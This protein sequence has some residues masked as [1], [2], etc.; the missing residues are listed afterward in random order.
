MVRVL[1]FVLA[2]ALTGA[3]AQA[4]EPLRV[5]TTVAQIADVVREVAGERAQVTSLMGE[6]VDPHTYRQTRADIVALKRA[7]LVLYNGLYLEAQ[8]EDLLHLL[9]RHQPVIA[10]GEFIPEDL[11]L[12]HLQYP[13]KYDPHIWMDVALW[14]RT[15]PPIVEVLTSLD[16]EGRET[17]ESRGAAYAE[18][19]EE[20]DEYV[21]AKMD[22]VPRE[23]RVLLTAHDAFRYFARAYDVEVMGIQGLSTESEAG[24]ERIESLVDILVVRGIRA[25][26]VETSVAD[27]NILAL[28]EGAAARGHQ[29]MVG[30]SLFSDAMGAP[31]TYEGT[32]IGMLDHNATTVA[33]ALGGAV[34][35]RGWQGLLGAGS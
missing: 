20:L 22:S 18:R 4:G 17:Y 24:L 35:E 19:L 32:F 29:V 28:V 10:I 3:T 7:D 15:V 25:V 2:L 27:R 21:R 9:A 26:F 34:P 13:G 11:R 8:L 14:S 30:G 1:G 12:S 16:P 23:A 6:G 31:D 5:V 33:R